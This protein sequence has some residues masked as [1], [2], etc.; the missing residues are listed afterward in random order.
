MLIVEEN[1]KFMEFGSAVS[2]YHV[3][4]CCL[5]NGTKLLFFWMFSWGLVF[6]MLHED[7]AITGKIEESIVAPEVCS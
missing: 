2:P 3:A 7:I 5:Y 4:M 1:K 6:K